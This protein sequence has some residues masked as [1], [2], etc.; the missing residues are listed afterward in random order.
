MYFVVIIFHHVLAV[1]QTVVRV[2]GIHCYYMGVVRICGRVVLVTKGD[3]ESNNNG[4][5]QEMWEMWAMKVT[6]FATRLWRV[7]TTQQVVV[8]FVCFYSSD[9]EELFGVVAVHDNTCYNSGRLPFC[10]LFFIP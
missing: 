9:C 6:M 2:C 1:I 4:G 5:N 8:F 3:D 10:S 7:E